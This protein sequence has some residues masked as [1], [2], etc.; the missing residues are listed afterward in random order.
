MSSPDL[1][2]RRQLKDYGADDAAT[3]DSYR[4]RRRTLSNNIDA[5]RDPQQLYMSGTI[6]L[7][8]QVDPILLADCPENVALWLPSDLPSSSRND[9]CTPGLPH[10]EYRLR[11]AIA[12]NALQDVRR[13]LR[14]SQAINTKAQ[15]HI[16]NTQRTRTKG[17]TDRIW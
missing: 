16:S 13:F 8:D 10:I 9:W 4:G 2:S 6:H 14:F 5:I 3:G 15:S 17:H 7:L 11:Y 1:A 12:T